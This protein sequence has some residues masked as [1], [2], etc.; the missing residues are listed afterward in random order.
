MDN[1]IAENPS[2]TRAKWRKVA[3]GGMQPGFDDNHTDDSFLEGMVMNANVVK[4]DMLK[5]M[6]DS[7]S[8]SQYLCI[9]VLVGLFWNYTLRSTLDETSLL[10]LDV[11]LLGSDPVA[12]PEQSQGVHCILFLGGP[13]DELCYGG[14]S[15]ARLCA[16]DKAMGRKG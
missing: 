13:L 8:I 2:P 4:R 16:L 1:N 7:V 9:V 14:L 3:Y 11:S 10:Y 5:V 15:Q 12:V 6:Q